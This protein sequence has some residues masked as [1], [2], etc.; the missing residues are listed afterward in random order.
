MLTPSQYDT[1]IHVAATTMFAILLLVA[2][3]LGYYTYVAM[4][5]DPGGKLIDAIT[6]TLAQQKG[7]L[8]LAGAA[9]TAVP[10]FALG[11]ANTKAGRITRR[12]WTYVIIL[13]LTYAVAALTSFFL[14]PTEINL[15]TAQTPVMADA[16]ALT[17]S[18][19]ALTYVVAI[20][21]LK[22]QPAATANAAPGKSKP[23]PPAAPGA[24]S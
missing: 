1:L 17:I 16:T 11:L 20:L 9:V 18:T 3:F 4:S 15:G 22:R 19:F 14:D 10:A 12:G 13:A 5:G 6:W 23:P 2:A 24:K 7:L 21:G 8:A